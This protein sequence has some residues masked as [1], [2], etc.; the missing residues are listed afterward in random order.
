MRTGLLKQVLMASVLVLTAFWLGSAILGL[1]GKVHLAMS[2]ARDV[3][4]RY[5]D[6]E[7]RQTALRADVTGLKT[8]RGQEAAIRQAFGVAK[9]GEEVIVV[10][11]QAKATTTESVRAWWEE[12]FDWF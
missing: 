12:W 6:L 8:L 10:V 11:P 3:E 2:G 7:K 5:E 9:E 4:R 1:L